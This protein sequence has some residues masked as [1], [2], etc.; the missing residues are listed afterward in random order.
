MKKL[1]RLFRLERIVFYPVL[2]ISSILIFLIGLLLIK[3]L[4]GNC[5]GM[6]CITTG[7]F[8]SFLLFGVVI[9]L[10]VSNI[11]LVIK[12]EA[13]NK[14]NNKQKNILTIYI[15]VVSLLIL[16]LF[17]GP[18][19]TDKY[20]KIKYDKFQSDYELAME[21]AAKNSDIGACIKEVEKTYSKNYCVSEYEYC[22][23][24]CDKYFGIYLSKFAIDNNDSD[25]CNDN[26]YCFYEF[27]KSTLDVN[28]CLKVTDNYFKNECILTV[29]SNKKELNFCNYFEKNE[30]KQNC[31]SLV[32]TYISKNTK[33][34]DASICSKIEDIIAK[35]NCIIQYSNN[36]DDCYSLTL[37]GNKDKCINGLSSRIK[38]NPDNYGNT[39]DKD[40]SH[41]LD[42]NSVGE[43]NIIIRDNCIKNLAKTI[44]ECDW[45]SSKYT[46]LDCYKSIAVNKND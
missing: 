40:T 20:Y 24:I 11:F 37:S 14:N 27:G 4:F 5:S 13:K 9:A 45:I 12:Y 43:S 46:K 34:K 42:I 16:A 41:C 31:F 1:K 28:Y 25:L 30:D 32:L 17:Y 2:F 22:R 6:S 33:I 23:N 7:I 44:D 26:I 29:A 10:V 19:I 15:V 3:L 36:F 18:T 35:E 39:T 21:E 38:N 8:I